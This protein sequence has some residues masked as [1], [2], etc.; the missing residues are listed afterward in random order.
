[1]SGV[2]ARVA[3]FLKSDDYIQSLAVISTLRPAVDAFGE[4]VGVN[5][6]D[7]AVRANRLALL[8][9]LNA[10]VSSIAELSEIVTSSTSE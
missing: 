5:A 1:M 8:G 6:Q 10:Q 2:L 9:R 7:P 3:G 4:Q